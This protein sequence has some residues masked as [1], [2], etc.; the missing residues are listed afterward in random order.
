MPAFVLL[1]D[2]KADLGITDAASDVILL[3]LIEESGARVEAHCRQRLDSRTEVEAFHE[4]GDSLILAPDGAV[5][6]TIAIVSVV[7]DD[8]TLVASD[9]DL[10]GALLRRLDGDGRPVAWS[11]DA[12]TVTYTGGFVL[13]TEGGDPP[14]TVPVDLA[15]AVYA[16]VRDAWQRRSIDGYVKSESYADGTSQTFGTQGMSATI[17]APGGPLARFRKQ[18]LA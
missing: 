12:V 6:E 4:P 14:S 2:V 9:W 16:L 1:S 8:E 18:V 3:R 13:P 11:A 7:E 10:D 15:G 17:W 5:I